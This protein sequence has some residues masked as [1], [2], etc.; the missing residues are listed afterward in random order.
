M[1]KKRFPIKAIS[2]GFIACVV[3]F[4]VGCSQG[5]GFTNES[6]NSISTN[7]QTENLQKLCK[8]WGY[9]KYTHPVFLLGQKDWD[10]ELLE[11][12]P[13]VQA[14]KNEAQTNEILTNW[15]NE[16]GPV[17]YGTN[18]WVSEWVNA[19][20]EQISVQAD[21]SWTTDQA[22][23][24]ESLV[25]GLSQLK[26]I[27][28]IRNRSKAPMNFEKDKIHGVG[29]TTFSNEKTY[30]NMD[31]SD[32]NYRL[33]GLFRYWNAMEYYY[34]YLDILDDDWNDVLTEFIPQIT[35]GTDKQ[36]YEL[37][38]V[39]MSTKLHDTHALFEDETFLKKE[40]GQYTAPVIITKAEGKLVV[41]YVWDET[42]PLLP[43]DILLQ[44]DGET[45]DS[46]IAHRKQY[47]SITTDEKIL[48]MIGRFL[49]CSH[50]KVMEITVLRDNK[51][52]TLTVRGSEKYVP[53]FKDPEY[54]HEL[55]NNNIGLINPRVLSQGEL[56]TIMT[57]FKDTNGLIVDLRQY[58]SDSIAATLGSYLVEKPTPFI[59]ISMPSRAVL[60]T[61]LKSTL[62]S[63][64][65]D[66][67]EVR[68]DNTLYYYENK[69]VILIDEHSSSLPEYTTMAVR[70][71]KNV[72]VMGE[73][74]NG[75][76]GDMAWLPLPGG[77]SVAFSCLGFYDP[78]G[79]QTQRIGL[80]PDIYINRTI[81]GVKDGRDE[82]IEQAVQ[83]IL[84]ENQTQS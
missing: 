57:E 25:T 7:T 67:R 66:E 72:V 14:A 63:S 10:A 80:S 8:V 3:V 34:P 60:G 83:Y 35:E 30:E 1:T 59:L 2:I 55:L 15:F 74:S 9:V 13:E 41:S 56:S 82:F 78:D 69:T 75:T 62:I 51:E 32:I 58:P 39:A 20:E 70:N 29:L 17:D 5:K 31:Y 19:T 22:Y 16:L 68:L 36:S 76:D 53:Q 11:L 45:M 64:G 47:C 23:L 44:L 42:C 6:P 52:L 50:D 81:A 48:T 38:L 28:A 24:G 46:I 43:G 61:F 40:F 4:I 84:D 65:F 12:I 77:N 71:G 79:G 73:N 21:L 33:L 37:T 26:E 54:S 18:S 49:L 27:P